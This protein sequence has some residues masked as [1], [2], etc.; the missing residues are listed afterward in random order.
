[1]T[2]NDRIEQFKSDVEELQLK[3]G[4]GGAEKVAG[5]ISGLLMVAAVVVGV[6]SYVQATKADDVR[7]QNELIVLGLVCVVLAII[8][9]ALFVATKL[10]RFWRFWMLRQMYE[11]QTHIDQLVERLR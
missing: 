7:D 9:A 6:G 3:T 2:S 4:T 11:H 8:G 5:R 10:V 1:M